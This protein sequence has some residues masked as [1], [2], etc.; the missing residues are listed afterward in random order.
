[1][2]GF[3][4]N[5]CW[6]LRFL[7]L[8]LMRIHTLSLP[9]IELIVVEFVSGADIVVILSHIQVL[10]VLWHLLTTE[11]GLLGLLDTLYIGNLLGEFY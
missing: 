6:C 8:R 4:L 10:H 5:F 11:F 7:E 3:N 1:M 9:G 2:V